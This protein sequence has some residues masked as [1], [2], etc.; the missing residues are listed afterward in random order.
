MHPVQR[1]DSRPQRKPGACGRVRVLARVLACFWR[2]VSVL[3]MPVRVLRTNLV[4]VSPRADR[5]ER[6]EQRE[7]RRVD[8]VHAV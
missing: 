4:N 7:L 5:A 1:A 8:G 6:Q 3:G 2:D